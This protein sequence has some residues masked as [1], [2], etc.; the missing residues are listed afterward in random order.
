MIKCFFIQWHITDRCDQRCKHCYIYNG[1][2]IDAASEMTYEDMQYVLFDLIEMC[3]KMNKR[4]VIVLTGGA[5]LLHP[6]FW[7]IM[8]NIRDCNIETHILGNPFHLNINVAKRLSEYGCTAFQ[9][10]LDGL[11][12]T[13]DSIRKKGSFSETLRRV[14][15]IN[16]AGMTSCIMATVSKSNI[17]EIPE[18]VDIVVENKVAS[19]SFSRYCPDKSGYDSIVSANEYRDFLGKMWRKF[20]QYKDS[21]TKF[22]LKDH[23]WTLFLYEKGLYPITES[24]NY[25][26]DGCHCGISHISVLPNGD[27]YACRRS[28]T[29]VGH[30]PD[31]SLYDIFWGEKMEQY[32]H[33]DKFE[34][35]RN[36]E[37]LRFC[38]GCPSVANCLHGNFYS[39]DPQCWK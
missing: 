10:S 2:D 37:L 36:C 35:C 33:F 30:V 5:P 26:Y 1:K 29:P 24:Q 39:K 12:D 17:K 3:K 20:E 21:E 27:V 22:G 25:I 18:L 7:R 34:K 9:M 15:D 38:R 16:D 19:F 8:E 32:R 23:L 14:K 6:D 11:M 31:E 28:Y 13:H 4:P